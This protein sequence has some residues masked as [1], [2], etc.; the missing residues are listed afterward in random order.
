MLLPSNYLA[1]LNV[2]GWNW[3]RLDPWNTDK[4]AELVSLARQHDWDVLAL[5]DLHTCA[6]EIEIW[7]N[8]SRT[9][10]RVQR[11]VFQ[12][13]V[14]MEEFILVAGQRSGFLLSLG[15]AEAWRDSGCDKELSDDGRLLRL[16]N[17]IL[18]Q[19]YDFVSGYAPTGDTRG[20]RDFFESASAL[21]SARPNAL[22]LRLGD[23]NGHVGR[24][25]TAPT[26]QGRFGLSTP[27][28]AA[29]RELLQWLEESTPSLQVADSYS[30]IGHR[31]T[32]RLVRD[33]PGPSS[34]LA[35]V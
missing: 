29:G 2:Q 3:S 5:F 35:L 34:R 1:T 31:G 8:N 9:A 28:T 10:R 14:A 4:A 25:S 33:I 17:N 11:D 20:R 30:R 12:V 19:R 15:A 23:W 32:W 7:E 22:Q 24:L 6:G 27:T 16:N 13:I 18:D 21:S 26:V